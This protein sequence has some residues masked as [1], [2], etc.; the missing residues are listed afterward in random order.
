MLA[1]KR[2]GLSLQLVNDRGAVILCARQ[3][4]IAEG[5]RG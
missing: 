1:N 3:E 2:L 5:C 4:R